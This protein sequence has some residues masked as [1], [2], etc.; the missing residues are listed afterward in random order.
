I[1]CA[2]LPIPMQMAVAAF[3]AILIGCNLPIAVGLVWITN[4]LTMPPIFYFSYKV[5]VMVLGHS[6]S[7]VPMSFSYE[8]ITHELASIWWPLL[9][10]SLVC[11]VIFGI[12]SYLAINA[13]WI[14]QVRASW[15]RR[16]RK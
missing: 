14:F 6:D 5:G 11:G 13:I 9:T 15:R 3:F 7:S 2:F 12:L 10:G 1:F 16:K 4:P 8:Y